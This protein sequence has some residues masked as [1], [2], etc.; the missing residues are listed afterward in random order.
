MS[1][2]DLFLET[3]S[4]ILMGDLYFKYKDHKLSNFNNDNYDIEAQ[5]RSSSIKLNE[6][7][8]LI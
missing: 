7:N 4:S 6:V 8:L 3:K 5:I 1:F 2:N